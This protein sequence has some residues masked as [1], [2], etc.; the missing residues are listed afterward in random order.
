MVA[1]RSDYSVEAVEAARSVL[2]ELSR[3]LGYSKEMLLNS[4]MR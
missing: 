3:L 4:C 2:L 1:R